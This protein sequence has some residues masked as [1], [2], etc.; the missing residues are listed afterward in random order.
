MPHKNSREILDGTQP[1]GVN[2]SVKYSV[3]TA[4]WGGTPTTVSHDIF[5]E[6][7]FDTSLKSSLMSGT[8]TVTSDVITLP[9]LSGLTDGI[10]YRVT[11]KFTITGGSILESYFR[12]KAEL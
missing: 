7:D 12:V 9:A 10:I 3:D 4:P 1:Q 6:E 5:D 2:E 11:V 8:P